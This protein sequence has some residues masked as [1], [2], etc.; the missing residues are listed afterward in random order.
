MSLNTAVGRLAI[1]LSFYISTQVFKTGQRN[2]NWLTLQ[3][4]VQ[5]ALLFSLAQS[6]FGN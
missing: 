1:C 3:I 4:C 6:D 2:L 5:L